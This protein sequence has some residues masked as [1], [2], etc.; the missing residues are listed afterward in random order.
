MGPFADGWSKQ[1]VEAVVARNDPADVLYVPIVVGMNAPDCGREWAEAICFELATHPHF[2][3]RGNAI[4]GL[5]HIAR[6]CRALNTEKAVPLIAEAMLDLSEYVRG[7]AADA[8]A[9]LQVFLGIAIPNA[10]EAG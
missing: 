8:A 7:H 3:V 1:E 2:N 6:T 9:D 5:A 10:D 4:L